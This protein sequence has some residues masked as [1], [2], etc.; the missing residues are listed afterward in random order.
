M[1]SN[2]TSL[3]VGAVAYDPRVVT[4]WEAF[5]G[6]FARR[7]LDVDYVLFSNYERQ[8]DALL[9]GRIDIAWHTNTAYVATEARIGGEARLLGMRDIDRDFSTVL[10]TRR[11][12]AFDDL[13]EVRG[14]RL[15]LGSRDS[16]HAAILPL[17]YLARAG[18]DPRSETDLI[19]FDS[20]V[21]KHGDTGNSEL[22]VARAVAEGI[23]DV[24]AMGDAVLSGLR[25]RGFAPAGELE[26]AWR[27]EPYYHC[28]FTALP[29]LDED[30]ARR[31]EDT[32]LAMD[33]NDPDLRTPMDLESVKRWH[34][35]DK[36]GYETLTQA[37]REQG[38]LT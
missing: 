34:P 5:R 13:A 17:H 6:Y 32:L 20:D 28:T 8:V 14:R 26:V 25:E 29:D 11:G 33:Y 9:E 22:H 4:I 3:V 18:I 30:L 36:Q 12:E 16:G 21:G 10:V 38:A 15:A 27:S 24:G 19:R 31:F 1:T 37:M 7:D 2:A 35:S 23:A